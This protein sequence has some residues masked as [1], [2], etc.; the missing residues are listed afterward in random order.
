MLGAMYLVK[1]GL[2]TTVAALFV[3]ALAA[4]GS[5]NPQ[6]PDAGPDAVPSC[7]PRVLLTGGTDVVAQ[8]WTTSTQQPFALT[9]GADFTRLETTT[10]AGERTGGQLLLAYPNVLEADKPFAIEIE[11]MIESV[12]AHNQ[13]DAAAAIMGSLTTSSGNQTDRDQMVYLDAGRLG[14]ADDTGTFAKNLLDGAYHTYRLS[15]DA[16]GVA[17]VTVDGTQALMRNA[18][19]SNGRIAIGDQTNDP[20]VDAVTRVRKITKLC[21]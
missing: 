10:L 8:G 17:R 14:W 1:A 13:Y 3:A 6:E 9:Y 15:R 19:S 21:P 11:L 20:S 7:V 12:A 5:V 16:G 18:F 2:K 4:C